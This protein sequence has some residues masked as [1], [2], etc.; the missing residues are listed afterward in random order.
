MGYPVQSG[1]PQITVQGRTF[2]VGAFEHTF[3]IYFI[4]VFELKADGWNQIF[5][6]VSYANPGDLLAAVQ[7]KGGIVKFIEW[8]VALINA[9]FASIFG[10]PSLPPG[11][12]IT[13]EEARAV[14]TAR[15]NQ[16]TL[17]VVNGVP[18]LG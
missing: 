1:A 4:G 6:A 2:A 7:A 14:V 8:I 10:A 9:F 16:L 5:N 11:E 12:P 3:G 15:I 13:D 17:T 18:R